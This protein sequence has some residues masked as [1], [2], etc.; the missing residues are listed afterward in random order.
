MTLSVERK[1]L[2]RALALAYSIGWNTAAGS[3][4][5]AS[6]LTTWL[7]GLTGPEQAY[8]VEALCKARVSPV[9]LASIGFACPVQ[10]QGS[11]AGT[12]LVVGA[13]VVL[14]AVLK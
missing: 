5:A 4:V 1:A 3:Q 2:L 6:N 12:I 10:R 13:V 14:I 9:W 7:L 11:R 8:A